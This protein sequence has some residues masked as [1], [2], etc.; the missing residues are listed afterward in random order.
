MTITDQ[1]EQ[2]LTLL[3]TGRFEEARR[4]VQSCLERLPRDAQL[5]G[6]HG[7]LLAQAG[8]L[9]A[10][11]DS[12]SASIAAEPD[13][14]STFNHLGNVYRA[15]GDYEGAA[16]SYSEALRLKPQYPE[17]LNNIGALFYRQG[18][19]TQASG[20]FEKALRLDSHSL[21]ILYNLANTYVKLDNPGMAQQLY[22]R[23]L[24][25]SEDHIGANHNLGILLVSLGKLSEAES[26]L[27]KALSRDTKALDAHYHLALVQGAQGHTEEA[28]RLYA[29]V[30]A[31]VP[32]HALA[33]HNVATLYLSLKEKGKALHHFK[34]A[35]ALNPQNATAQ[36]F[37]LAL[38]GEQPS[39]APVSFVKDLF[40]FYA[41]NYDSHL[42]KGLDYQVPYE[43][44]ALVS[45][46]KPLG[47]NLWFGIDIGCGTGLC[48]P[49]FTDI[50][51]R[52]VGIDI[53]SQMLAQAKKLDAYHRLHEGDI[54]AVLNHHYVGLADIIIAGDV[55]GYIG[56]LENVFKSVAQA[57]KNNGY[58]VLSIEL[59][60]DTDWSLQP[61]GRYQHSREY[62]QRTAQMFGLQPIDA[63][64]FSL[65]VQDGSPVPGMGLLLQKT[66]I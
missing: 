64:H 48:A 53:S 1:K 52:L 31:K 6:A 35:L 12:L 55:L 51:Y 16:R 28:I 22:E 30:L 9:P 57:L 49:S 3:Q 58:F 61:T 27:K 13:N 66:S 23:L 15:L 45:P 17:A 21:D 37:V 20:I 26:Y 8:N 11:R 39:A 38:E 5:L 60:A 44:R 46:Y 14:P 10:A 24:E 56:A 65:R 25:L 19:L 32:E 33:H 62:V 50:V 47:D 18:K 59:S 2:A 43:L 63:R 40:D 54:T 34:K 42:K 41:P 4:L 7:F 29:M 36:H